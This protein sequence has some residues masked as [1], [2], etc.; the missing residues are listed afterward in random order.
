MNALPQ[1]REDD[2]PR[3]IARAEALTL[4]REFRGALDDLSA[5]DRA[6]IAGRCQ[7]EQSGSQESTEEPRRE[8][9][10]A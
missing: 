1:R 3:E 5:T 7:T 6:A 9:E 10:H 4:L 2:D 8:P